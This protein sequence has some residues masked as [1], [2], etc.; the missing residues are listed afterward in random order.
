MDY[1]LH[2]S[3]LIERGQARLLE[4]YSENHHIIPRCIGGSD[5]PENL[6]RLTPEEHYVAHQLLVKMNPGNEKLVYAAVMMGNTRHT[7]KT[8]GWLKRKVSKKGLRGWYTD[9]TEQTF[10]IHKDAPEGWARGRTPGRKYTNLTE[11]QIAKNC[12]FRKYLGKKCP[13]KHNGLRYVSTGQCVE[14]MTS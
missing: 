7:N 12:G 8:Y 4:G 5:D 10:V 1:E 2:Y 9:G 6:V 11:R 3:T 13:V 14:C